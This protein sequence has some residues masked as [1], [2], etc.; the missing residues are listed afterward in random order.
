M[1]IEVYFREFHYP[2]G[3]Y[4]VRFSIQNQRTTKPAGQAEGVFYLSPGG[5]GPFLRQGLRGSVLRHGL[6]FSS[7]GTD[8]M[9]AISRG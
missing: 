7:R 4:Y 5:S 6:Q 3:G 2:F 1:K 8:R 9:S